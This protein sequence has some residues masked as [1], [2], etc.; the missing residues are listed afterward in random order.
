[1][2]TYNLK[3]ST[4][5]G[6]ETIFRMPAYD[7]EHAAS[8]GAKRGKVVSIEKNFFPDFERGMTL[9]ERYVL[10][11]KLG[12]MLG[13]GVAVTES[14]RLI[15]MHFQGRIRSCA[16]RLVALVE[17]GYPLTEAMELNRKDF[18]AAT[19]ALIR[20][21]SQAG[22]T[23]DALYEA[24]KFEEDLARS[25]KGSMMEMYKGIAAFV[26]AAIIMIGTTEYFGPMMMSLDILKGNQN[27]SV[28]NAFFVGRVLS[29]SILFMMTIGL[30]LLGLSTIG[31]RIA[32]DFS[33]RLVMRVPLYRDV[34]LSRAKY[35]SLFG[36][37][38]LIRTGVSVREA[39]ELTW[40]ETEDGMLKNDLKRALEAAKTGKSG[41]AQAM[42]MLDALDKAAL[43]TS[44][45]K[46]EIA[47]TLAN[48]ANDY[49]EAF[50]R[51]TA[52]LALFLYLTGVAYI[53]LA[54]G[55]VFWIT[56][57]PMLQFAAL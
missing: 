13:S 26:A 53:A 9:D 42:E 8:I 2:P 3:I 5:R 39:L 41:W 27:V 24:A 14:L 4:A 49:R 30:I 45:D 20:A 7:T 50:F 46:K 52:R 21:G 29:A 12:I 36:L 55:V 22:N 31:K 44:V 54:Q 16:K 15:S 35:V 19:I 23:A 48:L 56:V 10:M 43:S 32:A 17:Q 1:M 18:P 33:D 11:R 51:K 47:Q 57:V 37:S 38:L 6:I 34:A 40:R 28:D 25:R